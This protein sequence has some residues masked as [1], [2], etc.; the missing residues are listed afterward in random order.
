MIELDGSKLEGGGAILRMAIALATVKDKSIHIY[1]IRAQRKK[2]GL[3]VQHLEGV[4]AVAELCS[5]KLKGAELGSKEI[6]FWP[7][8]IES[9]KLDIKISTSGSTGLLF[10]ILKLPACNAPGDV[11]INIDGGG[12]WG[13][14]SPPLIYVQNVLLPTLAKMGYKADIKIARH[15]FYPV[16]GA[17]VTISVQPCPTLTPLNLSNPGNLVT[18]Q[19]ISIASSHL[20]PARVAE[21]Q[22]EAAKKY[23]I[24]KGYEPRIKAQ[25]VDSDCPGSGIVL[26]ASTDTGCILGSDGLGEKGKPAEKVG[27]QAAVRLAETLASGAGVDEHLSDQLLPFLALAKGE[28]LITAPELTLHAKTNI[29]VIEKF[30]KTKFQVTKGKPV[31]ISCSGFLE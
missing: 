20:K 26:W 7:G 9:K 19:G 11:T 29:W 18:L 10:Q 13:K 4:K 24:E 17:R 6:W 1:N 8:K 25:Y 14:W 22:A 15:G 28:S 31:K 30:L 2:P 23:L 16:G 5:G 21:R 27:R 12:T 3:R